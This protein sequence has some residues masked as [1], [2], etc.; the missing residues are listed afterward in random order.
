MFV[1]LVTLTSVSAAG[2][3][4]AAWLSARRRLSESR[5][6]QRALEKSSRVLEEERRVM[7]MMEAGAPLKEVLDTLTRAIENMAPECV[8]TILL[9]DADGQ[10]LLAGSGG[11]L[12]AEYMQAVNGLAIGNDVGACGTAAY[13]NET[14]IVDDIA[15]DYR[16][17]AARDFVMSFGLRACWSVPIRGSAGQVVGTFAMYHRQRA[18]PRDR[19]L[20]I[21]EAGALLAGNVIQRLRATQ[22]QLEND[23]RIML[24]ERAAS[25]GIWDLNIPNRVLTISEEMAA[26]L[27]FARSSVRLSV[28]ELRALVHPDDW[29]VLVDALARANDSHGSFRAE[30]RAVLGNGR[31]RF[32]R[33]QGRVEFEAG[34]PIRVA[35]ASIDVTKER[36]MVEKVEQA[37]RAKSEFLANMSHEIRTPMNGLLGTIQL[38]L[39]SGLTQ[40]QKEHV[41]VIQSCGEMLLTLV[42]DVLD[43]S[44]IEAGKLTLERI[45]FDL[46]R[47]VKEVAGLVRPAA[48]ARNLELREEFAPN[49]PGT[50]IGDPQRIRQVLLNLL[51]NAVKFTE[52]GMVGMVVKSQPSRD[53]IVDVCL[54]VRDTGIGI[55]PDAQ[56]AIF[57]PFTQADSSTTRRF[58]GTGLGLAI[59]QRLVAAMGGT[60]EIESEPGCGSTFRV[61][62]PLAR[63]ER[64]RLRAGTPDRIRPTIRPLRILVAED[65]AINQKI[66]AMILAKM[67]HHVDVVQNGELAVAAVERSDYDLVLMDCEMPVMDGYTATRAI[68]RLPRRAAVPI[69]A[70][71]AHAMAEDRQRCLAAGMDDYLSK[72]VSVDRLS[73]AIQS[74]VE[75]K[76]L[77]AS[78]VQD[79]ERLEPVTTI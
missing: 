79:S 56:R 22:R 76:R 32:F 34:I 30:C 21:V 72:P 65:N 40:E 43:L 53:G 50:L 49:L 10:H 73:E 51:S 35:G 19:E 41:D 11:S 5:R 39:D 26:H 31:I 75:A 67:G 38:L 63:G 17:A 4:T 78:E 13:R 60:L 36:E 37:T 12:P 1:E 66:A 57:E 77:D 42:N 61:T 45:P 18:K 48:L 27:G 58:G 28:D 62:I 64:P 6:E 74:I 2:F 3:S 24:A 44:K 47:L 59:C 33:S 46:E 9:L 20:R 16:F 15:T 54:A 14:V 7:E 55:S 68:R 25:L 52:R 69:V 8:C 70:M 29:T 23:E 71:T